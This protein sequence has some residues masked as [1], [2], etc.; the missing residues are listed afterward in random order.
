MVIE[1]AM[2][3]KKNLQVGIGK[4]GEVDLTEEISSGVIKQGSLN[5]K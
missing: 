2:I 4:A 3:V 5:T 1:K